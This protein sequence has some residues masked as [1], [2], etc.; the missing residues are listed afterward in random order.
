[1]TAKNIVNRIEKLEILIKPF[2]SPEIIKRMEKLESRNHIWFADPEINKRLEKLENYIEMEDRI[3]VSDVLNR[4]Q[5][6]E[7]HTGRMANSNSDRDKALERLERWLVGH[8]ERIQKI[9]KRNFNQQI[10][11]LAIMFREM[12]SQI[13]KL[14]IQKPYPVKCPA[15]N[16][17]RWSIVYE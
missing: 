2:E 4:I 16:I 3:T 13:D 10:S 1:M 7:N 9:E 6:I 14:K 8:V 15:C 5:A 12:Q 11:D 17:I